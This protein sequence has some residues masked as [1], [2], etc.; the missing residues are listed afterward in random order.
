MHINSLLS[1]LLGLEYTRV[2][3]CSFTDEGFEVEVA[4][5]WRTGRCSGCGL[6]CRGY[7]RRSRRWRHLD[8]AGMTWHLRYDIRRV[9]CPRCGIIVEYVPWADAGS[10][11]TRPF[12]DQ[13]GCLAQRCDKTAVRS[14]MRIAWRTVGDI[15]QRVVKR[16]QPVDLLDGLTHIGVDELS[17]RRHHQYVTIVIDHDTQRV[18]WAKEGKNADTLKAFFD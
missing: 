8:L 12:E 3:G 6:S 11:F 15:I 5:T 18:V 13:V 7:D 16:H 14:L 17:Y 1:E 9:N 4:P 2:R 10:W